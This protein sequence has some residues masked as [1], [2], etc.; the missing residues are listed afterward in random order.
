MSITRLTLDQIIVP[1]LQKL[2]PGVVLDVGSK[3]S[4]YLDSIRSKKYLRLDISSASEPDIVGDIHDSKLKSGYFDYVLATEV[5]EHLHDPQRAISEI[6]R[7]LKKGGKC[8]CSTRFIYHYHP[9]PY[10]YFRFTKD[11]LDYLFRKYSRV[12]IIPH[13]NRLQALWQIASS[14]GLSPI[15][16]PF[17]PLVARINFPDPHFPLGFVIVAVK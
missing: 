6:Y 3:H 14:A 5:L 13:G 8:I 16:N 2:K 1:R 11:S 9:D 10:D 17:T 12:E 15:M 7:L 4:P